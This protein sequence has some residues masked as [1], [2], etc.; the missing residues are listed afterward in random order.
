MNEREERTCL[1]VVDEVVR[2]SYQDPQNVDWQLEGE[3]GPRH[4]IAVMGE[5][6]RGKVSSGVRDGGRKCYRV[7][8]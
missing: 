6:G 4:G 1:T 7:V 2:V 3:A 5:G 8:P